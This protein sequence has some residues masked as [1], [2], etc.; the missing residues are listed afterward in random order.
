MRHEG[1][2]PGEHVNGQ[3]TALQRRCGRDQRTTL[4][5]VHG[6]SSS[7][8]QRQAGGSPGSPGAQPRPQRSLVSRRASCS[9]SDADAVLLRPC[10][11][12]SHPRARCTS[13]SP[14]RGVCADAE[15]GSDLRGLLERTSSA[16]SRMA[17]RRTSC[18]VWCGSGS[19][20]ET[21]QHWTASSGTTTGRL[22]RRSWCDGGLEHEGAAAAGA[23]SIDSRRLQRHAV[24]KL[25]DGIATPD[26]QREWWDRQAHGS[27]S[28][29]AHRTPELV[30]QMLRRRS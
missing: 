7:R 24:A 4:G 5:I 30:P 9:W 2:P 28:V 11:Q 21:R 6:L 8:Q 19:I 3:P 17:T 27:P 23:I 16:S 1:L 18:I 29:P 10:R 12:P 26:F 25:H 13:R 14:D 15:A 20:L 22:A